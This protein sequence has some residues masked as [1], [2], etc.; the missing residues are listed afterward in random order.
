MVVPSPTT[1]ALAWGAGAVEWS[2]ASWAVLIA[3]SGGHDVRSDQVTVSVVEFVAAPFAL[4]GFVFVV[5]LMSHDA[6]RSF[7]VG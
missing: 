5:P 6:S 2:V 3:V 1:P 4:C 7:D